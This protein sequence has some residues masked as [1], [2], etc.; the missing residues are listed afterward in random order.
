MAVRSDWLGKG[1][2]TVRSKRPGRKERRVKDLGPVGGRHDDHAGARLE[3][4]HVR[5]QLVERLLA[6]VVGPEPTGAPPAPDGI[7]LVDE[8]D[9]RGTLAGIGEKVPYPRRAHADEHLDEA[10]AGQGEKRHACFAGDGPRHERLAGTW[11]ADH[12]HALGA[13]RTRSGI[14]LG[15]LEE[16]HDL[17]DL[18]LGALV[19]SDVGKACRRLVFVVQ[20]GL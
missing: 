14:A 19:A 17:H 13:D 15:V 7:D 1:I 9:G 16:V 12:E 20:L 11:R 5:Q 10:R 3:P 4:V 6:L 2:S 8:D 18:G